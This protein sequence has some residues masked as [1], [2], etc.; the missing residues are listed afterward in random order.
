MGEPRRYAGAR[1]RASARCGQALPADRLVLGAPHCRADGVGVI[2]REPLE[3]EGRGRRPDRDPFRRARSARRARGNTGN[4]RPDPRLRTA[5][6]PPNGPCRDGAKSPGGERGNDG[7]CPNVA[8]GYSGRDELRR[9]HAGPHPVARQA[10]S[11]GRRT[12]GAC[13][14]RCD[15]A[16]SVHGRPHRSGPDHSYERRDAIERLSALAEQPVGAGN[17]GGSTSPGPASRP[18]SS[19]STRT[20]ISCPSS[21]RPHRPPA[22]LGAPGC[23][24]RDLR[25]R[26]LQRVPGATGPARRGAP[27]PARR[28]R[29]AGAG[30]PACPSSAT[31][32]RSAGWRRTWRRSSD[33]GRCGPA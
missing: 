10:G 18:A 4:D 14:R 1:R 25:R 11:S 19:T 5:R 13:R 29:A 30:S 32:W 2:H 16:P 15:Q 24:H 12:G 22:C 7:M 21:G 20:P 9:R 26:R 17:S 28:A 6:R 27:L 8:L 23:D 33:T 3:G 31:S